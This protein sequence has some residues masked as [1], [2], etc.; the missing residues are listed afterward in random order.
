[1]HL[2]SLRRFPLFRFLFAALVG[3]MWV[4]SHSR[5]DILGIFL[6]KGYASGLISDRG[7]AVVFHTNITFGDRR[8]YT[9]DRLTMPN[10]EFTDLRARLY[11][12]APLPTKVAGVFL[13]RSGPEAF[14]ELPGSKYQYAVTPFWMLAIVAGLPL[15]LGLRTFWVRRKWGA[16]GTCG[17]CGYDLR[18][19]TGRCPEC[20]REI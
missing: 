11:D 2:T 12:T 17:G 7:K 9:Y 19:S 13:G 10:E 3:W 5:S 15:M 8:A 6:H 4:R 18:A 1:M 20:G 14:E 16:A